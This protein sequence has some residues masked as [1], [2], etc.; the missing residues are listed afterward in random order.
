MLQEICEE[1]LKLSDF[2]HIDDTMPVKY[3]QIT[4]VL[5]SKW[6]QLVGKITVIYR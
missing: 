1:Y 2:V 3:R 4:V 6:R 5:P